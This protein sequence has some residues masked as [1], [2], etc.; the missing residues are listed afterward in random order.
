MT[1]NKTGAESTDQVNDVLRQLVRGRESLLDSIPSIPAILQPLL[2]ELEQ[3]PEDIDLRRVADLISRDESLTAQSLRVANSPLLSRSQATT[4]VLGAVRTLGITKTREMAVSCTIARIGASQKTLD[5]T[6]FWEH[7]LGCAMISRKL[8]RSVGF[9]NPD[10]AYLA[11]LL[12]DIGY[13][14]NLILAPQQMQSVLETAAR[15]RVFAGMVEESV[16]GFTHC[17]SGELLANKWHFSAEVVEV[18]RCH[19]NP[20]SAVGNPALVMIVALS[21]RMCRAADLGLGYTETPP[22]AAVWQSDWDILTQVCPKA[23]L[24]TWED[25]V[26]DSDSYVVEIRDLV[27]RILNV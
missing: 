11:G 18:I 22:D 15:E 4:S 5:P 25:F 27:A 8:A 23:S 26:R 12:H 9:E 17:Q 14:V 13:I 7:S 6:V 3:R 10:Q 1:R 20:K 16:L 24:M 19:H 21:D 2:R